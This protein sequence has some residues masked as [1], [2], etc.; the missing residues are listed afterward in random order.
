MEMLWK[1]LFTFLLDF[2][3]YL[4]YGVFYRRGGDKLK[5]SVSI[6]FIIFVLLLAGEACVISYRVGYEEGHRSSPTVV[7]PYGW[8]NEPP[9]V[10][11]DGTHEY[12]QQWCRQTFGT[13]I[14]GKGTRQRAL[15]WA[16]HCTEAGD[17]K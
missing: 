6:F 9:P 2:P 7:N 11:R 14:E 4:R 1:S 10:H 15:D 3:I 16:D 17:A 12:W 13:P 8:K 5:T